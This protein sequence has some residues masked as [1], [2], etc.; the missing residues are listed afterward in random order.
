MK[1][2]FDLSRFFGARMVAGA[3]T[4]A[5]AQFAHAHA[6]P[7]HQVPPAGAIVAATQN[8][9]A[10][11]FDDSLEPAFSS[12]DVTDA[13]GKSVT[14]GKATVDKANQ[15]H[16]SVALS[17][18]S[19]GKYTVTWVAVASDGHRTQGHYAFTVK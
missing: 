3:L 6:S 19:P 12:I 1:T 15:K 5:A 10:I 18:L 13:Q 7:T 4:L 16:M 9:V 14:R 17:A 8:E 11:E 2:K